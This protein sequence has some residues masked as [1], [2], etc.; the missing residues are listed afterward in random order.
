MCTMPHM[1]SPCGWI[2]LNAARYLDVIMGC[3]NLNNNIKPN[4][5]GLQAG[6]KSPSFQ[7]LAH[8]IHLSNP[9]PKQASLRGGALPGQKEYRFCP[10]FSASSQEIWNPK[11]EACDGERINIKRKKTPIN[12]K[13]KLEYFIE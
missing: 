6:F 2:C 9:V 8:G 4:K 10:L 11:P 3:Y 13:Y 12:L 1:Q 5:T 7:Y